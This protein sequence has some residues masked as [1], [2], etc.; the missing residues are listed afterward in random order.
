MQLA[1]NTSAVYLGGDVKPASQ[2]LIQASFNNENANPNVLIC[3][4]IVGR[5]GL[6]LHKA[7]RVVLLF[8]LE[9]NPGVVEQQIGRVDR[10]SSCWEKLAHLWHQRGDREVAFPRIE[11][12]ALCFA[13]TYDEYQTKRLNYRMALLKAQLFGEFLSGVETNDVVRAV[14]EGKAIDFSPESLST[15]AVAQAA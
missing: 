13:G 5:E 11:V 8:H 6:N 12:E 2:R 9:L 7:C 4:S 15:Q 14:L 10:I 3:Q 1:S